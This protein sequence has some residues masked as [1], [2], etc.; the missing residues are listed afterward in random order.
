VQDSNGCIGVSD[1]INVE[2]GELPEAS[3]NFLQTDGYN[4]E[5]TS[6]SEFADTWFW[7][8]G[9]GNTS[10]EENPSFEF[11]FDTDWPVTLVVSNSCGSD[12]LN[13]TVEVIKTSIGNAFQNAIQVQVTYPNV[14][15]IGQPGRTEELVWNLYSI[16]GALLK[17]GIET[18]SG[19]TQWTLPSIANGIYLLELQS[20]K[21]RSVI[22]FPVLMK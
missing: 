1:N 11:L 13:T 10:S 3:F 20:P 12:T 14:F 4:V 9:S 17:T 19:F 8:F 16:N 21:I 15:I 18:V 7:D 2:A 22:R 6:T 5:F